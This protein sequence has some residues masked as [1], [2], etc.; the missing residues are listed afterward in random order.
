MLRTNQLF[1]ASSLSLAAIIALTVGACS[2]DEAVGPRSAMELE[3]PAY[4][5]PAPQPAAARYEV[6]YM[7]F[8]IDHHLAGI[9]KA[10][11]CLDRAINPELIAMCEESIASQQMQID[12]YRTWLSVWYGI[13]YAGEIPQSS[14]PD[15]RELSEL[16]GEAFEDEFLTEMSKHHLRIIKE[17]EKAVRMVFHGE[18]REQAR[19]TITKQSQGVRMMQEWDCAWYD[20]C[21]LGLVNQL[22]TS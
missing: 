1:K 10:E 13:Q 16:S 7:Q 3:G 22:P 19:L 11:L 12:L 9:A 17:S 18:L 8:S 2:P 6:Y 21:R 15:I 5:R 20:D 14:I 4:D